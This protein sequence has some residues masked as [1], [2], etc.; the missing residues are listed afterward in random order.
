MLANFAEIRL[1]NASLKFE[2]SGTL[3]APQMSCQSDWCVAPTLKQEH[4]AKPTPRSVW[5]QREQ[6]SYRDRFHGNFPRWRQVDRRYKRF[7]WMLLLLI[8]SIILTSFP[9]TFCSSWSLKTPWFLFICAHSQGE[10]NAWSLLFSWLTSCCQNW[11]N[12]LK[13]LS[14]YCYLQPILFHT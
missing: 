13:P 12:T 2:C 10:I 3:V 14:I 4:F 5:R 9:R 1:Q 8:W 6:S 11:D 7:T